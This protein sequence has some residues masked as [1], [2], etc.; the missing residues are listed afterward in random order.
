M[1]VMNRTPAPPLRLHQ[2]ARSVCALAAAIAGMTW[3]SA[4]AQPPDI[5]RVGLWVDGSTL[6]VGVADGSPF[7]AH[8][9]DAAHRLDRIL[10]TVFANGETVFPIE[11]DV[12][13]QNIRYRTGKDPFGA[14]LREA[15]GKGLE[16]LVAFELLEWVRPGSSSSTDVFSR[17]PDL[18][19]V[20]TRFPCKRVEVGKFA[21]PFDP[22]VRKLLVNLVQEF[23]WRYP[24]V[25]GIVLDCRLSTG[26]VLGYSDAARVA[27]IRA[28]HL[29]PLDLMSGGG[30]ENWQSLVGDWYHWRRD[31]ISSL[32]G[33]FANAYKGANPRGKV[34]A[35]GSANFYRLQLGNRNLTC[36]D[37]L[38]WVAEG[39]VDEMLLEE[40]WSDL[41]NEH[42]WAAANALVGKADRTVP[43]TPVIRAG[44]A[45]E[46]EVKALG[47]QPK[48]TQVV[49]R[50]SATEDLLSSIRRSAEALA[51]G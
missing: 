15:Q 38:H 11:S 23:A 14:F 46:A 42:L 31:E 35:L 43:L 34:L 28:K 5:P 16:V 37:W 6:P 12:F 8:L 29:D 40:A 44:A 13:R 2:V 41:R 10:V 22:E 51:G 27:Y 1:S 25:A 30:G 4:V 39:H 32:V 3:R 26:E 45:V 9:G 47:Q 17:H 36:Q 49:L 19:E 24:S 21:S 33:E 20:N 18:Q 48:L 50:A 7:L